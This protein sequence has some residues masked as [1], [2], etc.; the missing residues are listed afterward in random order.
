MARITE[1]EFKQEFKNESFGHLYFLYG[2]EK[3]LINMYE[4]KLCIKLMGKR[5]SEFNYHKFNE[6]SDIKDIINAINILPFAAPYN[7]VCIEDFPIETIS[8]SD[9]K[10]FLQS[11]EDIPDMT[12]I[13]I[14]MRTKEPNPKKY[15]SWKR[16]IDVVTKYG[17]V[18]EFNKKTIAELRRQIVSWV[19]KRGLAI[20]M[21]N[22]GKIIEYSGTD[23]NTL[24]NEINKLCAFVD[25]NEILSEHIEKVVTKNLSSRVYDMTEA[26]VYGDW[27]NA[28][29]SL[30][31]LFYQQEEPIKILAEISATY[32]DMYRVKIAVESG[33][34]Y[35][36]VAN[37]FDYKRRE[38]RL[39]KADR[40]SKRMSIE[41]ICLCIEKIAETNIK[42]NSTSTNKRLLLEKLIA[43][44]IM[45][46][47]GKRV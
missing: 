9:N 23:L 19:S 24:K 26:M 5:P 37:D 1:Q 39:K 4:Q 38:F 31:Q 17:T 8:E 43:Y 29:K 13:V 3:M 40:A 22:A 42:M 16:L 18:V 44:L 32:V 27:D 35:E 12:V 34:H 28:F 15:N 7:Y 45:E 21:E 41:S 25:G 30:N 36:D 33:L 14:A 11:L 2:E 46:S 20:S 10:I 47:K 6:D